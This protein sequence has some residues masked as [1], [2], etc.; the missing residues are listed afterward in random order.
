MNINP[1]S[2]S[3]LEIRQTADIPPAEIAAGQWADITADEAK[4]LLDTP[5]SNRMSKLRELRP[6]MTH[7]Q[8]RQTLKRRGLR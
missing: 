7:N 4:V 1:Q 8:R 5:K 3:Y 6:S 2:P